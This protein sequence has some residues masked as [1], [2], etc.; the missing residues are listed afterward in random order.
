MYR[1]MYSMPEFPA[2]NDQL[3]S[4]GLPVSTWCNTSAKMKH[5]AAVEGDCKTC[6]AAAAPNEAKIANMSHQKYKRSSAAH[7]LQD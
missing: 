3:A 7:D 5:A 6:H 2:L 1:T 4:C